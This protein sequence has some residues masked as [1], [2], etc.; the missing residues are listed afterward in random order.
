M[1]VCETW[2]E[3]GTQAQET[4]LE[5]EPRPPPADHSPRCQMA[6]TL[7]SI[8]L[9]APLA[10]WAPGS[11]GE[12]DTRSRGEPG[13][14]NTGPS[15]NFSTFKMGMFSLAPGTPRLRRGV[16]QTKGKQPF[17]V[18]TNKQMDRQVGEAKGQ[19]SRDRKGSLTWSV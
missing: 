13:T 8:Q 11:W 6:G 5:W 12:Y 18:G 17:A 1:A 3:P 19:A 14:W 15:L 16:V 7:L 9:Y 10:S 4:E 2:A